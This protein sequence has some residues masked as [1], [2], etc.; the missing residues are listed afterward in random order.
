MVVKLFVRIS[1]GDIIRPPI[2]VVC[3]ESFIICAEFRGPVL[4]CQVG[5]GWV[6]H[7]CILYPTDDTPIEE[8]ISNFDPTDVF[9][10]LDVSPNPTFLGSCTAVYRTMLALTSPESTMVTVPA[11][12]IAKSNLFP[13]FKLY[14]N[15]VITCISLLNGLSL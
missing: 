6:P 12:T 3:M 13:Q 2:V 14:F 8:L 1:F 9:G 11:G 7:T 15:C 10:N 5:I 4:G